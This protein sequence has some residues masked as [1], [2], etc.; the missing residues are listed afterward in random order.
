MTV[1]ELT[2]V[3]KSYGEGSAKVTALAHVSLSVGATVQI[4]A[5]AI[6]ARIRADVV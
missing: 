4:G 1:L 6:Q 2:N 5:D 3:S